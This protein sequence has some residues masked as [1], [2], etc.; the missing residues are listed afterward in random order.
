MVI[1]DYACFRQIEVVGGEISAQELVII[2]KVWS[3]SVFNLVYD[4]AMYVV[5]DKRAVAFGI[6]K[7]ILQ[8][9]RL[10]PVQVPGF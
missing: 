1:N 9:V 6:R 8:A 7:E 10:P 4:L 5:Y 2:F 3:D